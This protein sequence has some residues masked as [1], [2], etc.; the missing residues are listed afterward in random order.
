MKRLVVASFICFQLSASLPLLEDFH[1]AEEIAHLYEKPLVVIHKL[2][3][4]VQN[5]LFESACG[6]EFV[7]VREE[8]FDCDIPIAILLDKEG[9]EITRIGYEE[10]LHEEFAKILKNRFSIYQKLCFDYEKECTEKELEDLYQISNELGTKYYKERILDR[11][12]SM[13]N[14]VFFLL[15]K[16]ASYVNRGEKNSPE[17][18]SIKEMI[19]KRDP[20][21]EKESKLRLLLLDFEEDEIAPIK[22]Y[23]NQY[24]RQNSKILSKLELLISR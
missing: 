18:K 1:K 9:K 17:A 19:E 2:D 8:E 11:G 16:Y 6:N 7:F 4:L 3:F 14:G 13:G 5:K 22:E 15:E 23:M 21:N 20:N 12:C 24:G 10:G